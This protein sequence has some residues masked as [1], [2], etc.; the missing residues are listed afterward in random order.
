MNNKS[1]PLSTQVFDTGP[2]DYDA[3]PSVNHPAG[4]QPGAY[5]RQ[6]GRTGTEQRCRQRH[7]EV[8]AGSLQDRS[9]HRQNIGRFWPRSLGQ[10]F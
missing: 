8:I 5:Q 6:I 7:R 2:A 1:M 4:L 9:R 3:D 10:Y